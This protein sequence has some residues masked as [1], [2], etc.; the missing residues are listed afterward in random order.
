[1]RPLW[2]RLHEDERGA[3]AVEFVGALPLLLLLGMA[4]WQLL[5]V[6]HVAVAT[7]NAARTGARAAAIGQDPGDAA[8]DSL[9][10][11]LHSGASV[12]ASGAEVEVRVPVPVIVR[13]LQLEGVHI[14]RD[15]HFPS[16]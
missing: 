9:P 12:T 4:A 10:S 16:E 5:L 11:W 15:A 7:E 6:G 1:M 13:D 2:R 3:P 14:T 8:R